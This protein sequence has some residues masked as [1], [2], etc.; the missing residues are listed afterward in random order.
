MIVMGDKKY[1]KNLV[2]GVVTKLDH[3]TARGV[4]NLWKL[5]MKKIKIDL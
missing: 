4:K 1:L 3:D 5:K 2:K